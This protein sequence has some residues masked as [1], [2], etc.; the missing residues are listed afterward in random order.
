[1]RYGQHLIALVLAAGY[2]L[3]T[4][5]LGTPH[6]LHALELAGAPDVAMRVLLQTEG[7]SWLHQLALGG[8]DDV[9]ALGQSAARRLSES[10]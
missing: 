1:M 4:G 10:R 7:P 2:R 9:G 3:Q 8:D 5:F 6:L